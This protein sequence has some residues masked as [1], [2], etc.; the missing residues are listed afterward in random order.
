MAVI[1]FNDTIAPFHGRGYR[2]MLECDIT[3]A[4]CLMFLHEREDTFG[5]SCDLRRPSENI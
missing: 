3:P 4:A 2:M 5:T 1:Q